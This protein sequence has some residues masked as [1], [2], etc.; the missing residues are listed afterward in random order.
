MHCVYADEEHAKSVHVAC[1]PVHEDRPEHAD[2]EERKV[3]RI[4]RRL[5]CRQEVSSRYGRIRD[6]R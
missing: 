2:R 6:Q 1:R 3:D 5:D 4:L